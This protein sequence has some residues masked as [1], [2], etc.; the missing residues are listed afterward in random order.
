M[1]T[2]I[3]LLALAPALAQPGAVS[4]AG[5]LDDAQEALVRTLGPDA[6]GVLVTRTGNG[7][8]LHGTVTQPRTAD[9]APTVIA[10]VL[11][12]PTVLTLEDDVEV[13]LDESPLERVERA[14]TSFQTERAARALL[15]DEFGPMARDLKL[16]ASG[17]D[18]LV[19]G[20]LPNSAAL[21][22]LGL[23]LEVV[24]E[25]DDAFVLVDVSS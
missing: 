16:E 13:I 12:D 17:D 10:H 8:L 15:R 19:T 4:S 5:A 25:V 24:P 3:P 11:D 14:W 7:V 22:R 21:R 20:E 9:L 6:A 23:R 2:L 18:L 1:N